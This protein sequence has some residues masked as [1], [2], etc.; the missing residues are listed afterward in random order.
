MILVSA[1]LL[2]VNCKYNGKNN[3][4]DEIIEYF[5][6]KDIIPV[7]P[8]Q[9]G[10]LSTPRLSAEI[11]GGDGHDVLEGT[12]RIVNSRGED[13]TGQFIKG[14]YETLKL[15]ET[16]GATKAILKAGSPSCGVGKIYN[17][18]FDGTLVEGSGVTAA[19]LKSKGIEVYSDEGS[20]FYIDEKNLR[21]KCDD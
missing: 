4:K 21:R 18:K 12:A 1:C 7:C 5:K 19:L 11:K 3:L 20:L 17:G 2:G 15:A 16:L 14:A 10:G 8:E 6:N 13:V 9:L